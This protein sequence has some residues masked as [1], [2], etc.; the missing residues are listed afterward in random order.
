MTEFDLQHANLYADG[1]TATDYRG[2]NP[3]AALYLPTD[4][5]GARRR[6]KP[7]KCPRLPYRASDEPCGA[8]PAQPLPRGGVHAVAALAVADCFE[9]P[10][11]RSDA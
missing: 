5:A 4:C 8:A 10:A 11:G 3:E 2:R 6:R 7:Q 1:P 9:A